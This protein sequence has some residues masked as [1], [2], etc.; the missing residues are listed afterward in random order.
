MYAEILYF[1]KQKQLKKNK[2][3][4]DGISVILE[5]TYFYLGLLLSKLKGRILNAFS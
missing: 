3:G 5:L 4:V 2:T 1:L